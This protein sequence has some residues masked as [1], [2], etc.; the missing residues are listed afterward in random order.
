MNSERRGDIVTVSAFLTPTLFALAVFVAW[1]VLAAMRLSLFDWNG[2]SPQ[3][4][5]VGMDNWLRLFEDAV[6][7]RALANNIA[8]VFLSFALQMPCA[9]GLAVLLERGGRRLRLF[10]VFYFFPMLMSTVA[11]GILFKYALDPQFGVVNG[12]LRGMGLE[13]FARTWLGDSRWALASVVG[14]VSWQSIPFYMMLFL[15]ALVGIPGEVREAALVDGATEWNYFWRIA[16]PMIRGTIRT[17]FVLSV[18]GSL[19]YFDLVWVMT[20]GGPAHASELMATYMYKKA[21]M[22]FDMG[23]GST[24]ASALFIVVLLAGILALGVSRRH[25]TEAA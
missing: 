13:R 16:F 23:Y 2:I 15:A 1:P 19:K 21:F 17:A 20:E 4:R 7:W 6:F 3:M 10:K 14:V 11:I 12:A 25:G 18:I 24:V 22:A 9:L 8:I 5:F